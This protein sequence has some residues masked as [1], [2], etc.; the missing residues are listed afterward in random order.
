MARSLTPDT[1]LSA[2]AGNAKP[3]SEDGVAGTADQYR[4]RVATMSIFPRN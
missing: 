1:N 2:V 3:A 4:H